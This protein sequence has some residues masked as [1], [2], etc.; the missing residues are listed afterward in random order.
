MQR[1][2]ESLAHM[3]ACLTNKNQVFVVAPTTCIDIF[4]KCV[5]QMILLQHYAQSDLV[6]WFP[7]GAK[8]LPPGY[9]HWNTSYVEYTSPWASA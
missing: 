4:A 1:A 9:K 3:H 6:T 2:S 7:R 8:I 5:S